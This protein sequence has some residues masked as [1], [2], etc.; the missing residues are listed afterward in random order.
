MRETL[1]D[2]STS[3]LTDRQ[4]QVG[5]RRIPLEAPLGRDERAWHVL[6]MQTYIA[7]QSSPP[8][9]HDMTSEV[10]RM[11]VLAENEA[12]AME[13]F[14]VFAQP[15]STITLVDEVPDQAWLDEMRLSKKLQPGKAQAYSAP[16]R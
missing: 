6:A 10:T 9:D 5:M 8:A 3:R 11:I 1:G 14:R 7:A 12:E 13:A 4:P 2:P 15:G 16:L